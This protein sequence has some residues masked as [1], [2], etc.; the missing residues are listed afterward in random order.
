MLS[1]PLGHMR[2]KA[3]LSLLCNTKE[4]FC[5]YS[6]HRVVFVVVAAGFVVVVAWVFV[7]VYVEHQS[8]LAMILIGL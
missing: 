4:L 2:N 8:F 3:W 1:G 6:N 5:R 7:V